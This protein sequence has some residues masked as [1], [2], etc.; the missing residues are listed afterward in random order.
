MNERT[1]D[2]FVRE[3]VAAPHPCALTSLDEDGS[4]YGVVVWC[5]LEGDVFT[6]NA[7]EGRWLRNLRRDP[8]VSLVIVDTANIHRH[9]AVQGR[10]VEIDL[11]EGYA[12]IDSLSEVY[13]GRRYG[14]S[15]PQEVPRFRLAIE[16]DRIRTFDLAPLSEPIR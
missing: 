5:A 9:V 13:E 1:R 2:D 11:D 6:V 16:P 14:Y 7:A 10:V 3:M 4:P 12:H 15:L 8:R